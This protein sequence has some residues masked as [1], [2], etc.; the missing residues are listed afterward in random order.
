VCQ[1]SKHTYLLWEWY[2]FLTQMSHYSIMVTTGDILNISLAVGFLLIAISVAYTFYNLS[3]TLKIIRET[4]VDIRIAKESLQ[5]G[6]LN[7]IKKI[8]QGRRGG[9]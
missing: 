7:I 6:A 2:T 3:Q 9:E 8:L 5:I 1:E 4:V